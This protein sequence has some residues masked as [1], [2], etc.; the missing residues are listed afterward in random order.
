MSKLMLRQPNASTVHTIKPYRYDCHGCSTAL[1]DTPKKNPP[2]PTI[3]A[4]TPIACIVPMPLSFTRASSMGLAIA[5]L[6]FWLVEFASLLHW[7]ILD[8]RVL[9]QLQRPDVRNDL[10]PLNRRKFVR[11]RRVHFVIIGFEFHTGQLRWT[12]SADQHRIKISWR[13]V[14]KPI[15]VERKRLLVAPLHDHSHSVA[16]LRMARR[17]E[18]I[19]FVVTSV[20]IVLSYFKRERFR[21]FSILHAPIKQIVFLQ[22]VSPSCNRS[23]YGHASALIVIEKLIGSKHRRFGLLPHVVALAP[24]NRTANQQRT[25]NYNCARPHKLGT[26]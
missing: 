15:N 12:K 24:D 6:R 3:A 11:N 7:N 14:P 8:R 1:E 26:S 23:F 19:I 17:T 18:R 5:A 25:C 9:A 20:Q 2:K 21:Q 22:I 4:T 16:A 10:P 13:G